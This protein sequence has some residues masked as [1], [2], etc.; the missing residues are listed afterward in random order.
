MPHQP[1]MWRNRK[2]HAFEGRVSE[3]SCGFESHRPHR[4]LVAQLESALDSESKG[5]EFKSRRGHQCPASVP[6]CTSVLHT[7]STS[8]NSR[9]GHSVPGRPMAGR[10]T[11]NQKIEV[12]I[13]AGEQGDAA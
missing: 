4:V 12:Q 9:A 1:R 8:F 5:C 3:S 7:E 13:F 6:D 2:P 11:L 10:L